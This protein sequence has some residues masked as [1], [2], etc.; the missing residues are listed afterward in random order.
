VSTFLRASPRWHLPRE[1]AHTELKRARGAHTRTVS[2]SQLK[3]AAR[4]SQRRAPPSVSRRL[5]GFGGA[6]MDAAEQSA[7]RKWRRLQAASVPGRLRRAY[8]DFINEP[9]Q[10]LLLGSRPI[11]LRFFCIC[12]APICCTFHAPICCT[13]HAPIFCTCHA[14]ISPTWITRHVSPD[15]DEQARSVSSLGSISPAPLRP[16]SEL[17]ASGSL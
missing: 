3:L 10:D 14:P 11:S 15:F 17:L 4:G 7:D 5:F 1:H 9:G 8:S 13:C 16:S 2:S 6:P 12:H